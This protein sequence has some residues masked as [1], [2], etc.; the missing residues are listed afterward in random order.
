[1]VSCVAKYVGAAITWLPAYIVDT[2]ANFFIHGF[3]A[4]YRAT[5]D[6]LITVANAFIGILNVPIDFFDGFTTATG[7]FL[8]GAVLSL[9]EPWSAFLTPFVWLF[10]IAILLLI[11]VA[12]IWG[13]KELIK[14]VKGATQQAVDLA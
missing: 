4:I 2:V 7:A 9:P 14:A 12:M 3:N 6:A 11:V 1:M 8:L 5:Y 13:V 10:V